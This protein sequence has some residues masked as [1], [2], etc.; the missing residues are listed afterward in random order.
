[1]RAAVVLFMACWEHGKDEIHN[2]FIL[3]LHLR[4]LFA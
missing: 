4:G 2:Q 1:M 3:G